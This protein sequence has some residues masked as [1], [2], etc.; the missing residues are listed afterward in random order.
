VRGALFSPLKDLH[1]RREAHPNVEREERTAGMA[2]PGQIL[3]QDQ[4]GGGQTQGN[5]SNGSLAKLNGML[6]G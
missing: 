2:Q 4:S 6:I 3:R 5:S 1:L